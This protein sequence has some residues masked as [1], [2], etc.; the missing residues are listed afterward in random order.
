MKLEIPMPDSIETYNRHEPLPVNLKNPW[1]A[2]LWAWLLPGSGHIYQG[3][4]AKGIL[5]MVCVLSTYFFGFALGEGRV[6]YASFKKPDFRYAYLCQVGVGLPALPAWVQSHRIKNNKPPLFGGL[7]VPPE[8]VDEHNSDEL[9]SWHKKLK[10]YFE[11]ATLY[12]MV[13]GL[14][15]ML[16]IYDAFAG[17]VFPQPEQKKRPPPEKG[18]SEAKKETT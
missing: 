9:A 4:Y 3:R 17:P 14:L 18:E 7:M 13:A 8:N 6:V 1:L 5:F 12:T 2:A 16:A 11:L 10:G 15:N